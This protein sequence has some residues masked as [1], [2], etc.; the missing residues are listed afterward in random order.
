MDKVSVPCTGFI[1]EKLQ[2]VDLVASNLHNCVLFNT[3]GFYNDVGKYMIEINL[4]L[5]A[6]LKSFEQVTFLKT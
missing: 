4:T 5:Q 2:D 6:I 1:P 3:E